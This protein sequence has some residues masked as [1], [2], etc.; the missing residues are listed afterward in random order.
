MPDRVLVPLDGSLLAESALPH[1][2]L[3]ARALNAPVDLLRVTAGPAHGE[4]VAPATA[5]ARTYLEHVAGHLRA[6]G[7]T[8]ATHLGQGDAAAAILT[9][10]AES[11]HL[12]VLVMATHGGSG[13]QRVA[14]GRVAAGVLAGSRVPLLL[15]RA[16]TLASAPPGSYGRILVA[17]DG[18]RAARVA[19]DLAAR[20]A[21]ALGAELVLLTV[22]PAANELA[23][24]GSPDYAPWDPNAAEDRRIVVEIAQY[25]QALLAAGTGVRIRVAAGEPAPEILRI[26]AS[27]PADLI[28]LGLRG[29]GDS[30][31]L[32]PGPV[33]ATVASSAPRPLLLVPDPATEAPDAQA[34]SNRATAASKSA[35]SNGLDK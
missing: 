21:R 3:L 9:T 5:A 31:A 10:A 20:L 28:V 30:A 26:A 23:W 13:R 19:L 25:A 12:T 33:A 29:Q 18:S 7:L 16:G 15:V 35:M 22:T 6:Q 27:L 2:R 4:T 32:G 1:A 14:F 34:G 24:P 17:L 8:V 11:A